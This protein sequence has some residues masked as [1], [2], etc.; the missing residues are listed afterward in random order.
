ML[1]WNEWFCYLSL[2]KIDWV[3]SHFEPSSNLC[4]LSSSKCNQTYLFK[5]SQKVKYVRIYCIVMKYTAA[6]CKLDLNLI[7]PLLLKYTSLGKEV[8]LSELIFGLSS[9]KLKSK[10]LHSG[11]FHNSFWTSLFIQKPGL[12]KKSFC[13]FVFVCFRPCWLL[14]T[15]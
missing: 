2:Y 9:I 11:C 4:F 1:N 10:Q 8:F 12:L 3:A 13:L 6:N 15:D 7:S 14:L 5:C